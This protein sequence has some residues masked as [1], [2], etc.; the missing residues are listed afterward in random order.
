MICSNEEYQLRRDRVHCHITDEVL[1][2]F[3]QSRKIE[4]RFLYSE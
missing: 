3:P 4:N 1:V 2:L